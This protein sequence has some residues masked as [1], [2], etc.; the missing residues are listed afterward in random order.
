MKVAEMNTEQLLIQMLMRMLYGCR[1]S[2]AQRELLWRR[3]CLAMDS[4]A[5]RGGETVEHKD[6]DKV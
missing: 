6:G 5:L 3:I 2:A 4:P 1:L